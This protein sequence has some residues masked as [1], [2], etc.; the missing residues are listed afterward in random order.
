MIPPYHITPE[1]LKLITSISEKLGAVSALNMERPS[2]TLRKKNRIKTL[3][4][5]L[6]IEG[7]TLTIPQIT[8]LI[9]DKRVLGPVKDILE[10]NNAIDVYDQL[11]TFNPLSLTALLRAHKMMMK[12]LIKSAGKFRTGQV[13]I[14]KGSKVAHLAPPGPL[15]KG[16][17]KDLISY[18]KTHNDPE[19]IK[20]CVFHYEL[21]FIHPFQD[22]NGR[23]GRF[24]QTLILKEKNPVF[25]YLPVEHLIKSK[26]EDY[27]KSLSKADKV[28]NATPFIV[29]ML[30]I[31]DLALDELLQ[32]QTPHH[33]PQ[34]R[35]EIFRRNQKTTYFTRKDYLLAFK[36]ISTATASRDL[37]LAVE[38]GLII[39]S[40]DK[41]LTSYS[42]KPKSS[43]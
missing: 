14:M 30:H 11:D 18:L 29:F 16:L 22:G 9:E 40:G 28:G 12:G 19:L 35:L 5:S 3:H 7:N 15:V 43:V 36:T 39:K 8:A 27:Y 1:I 34:N 41:R 6:A 25:E 33:T 13:G 20:S 10:V 21:E 4:S 23:M 17:I 2:A 31:I 38:Q 37:R 24:W 32:Q 42:F 26:Q